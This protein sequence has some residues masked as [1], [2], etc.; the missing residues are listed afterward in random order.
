MSADRIPGD[1]E[2]LQITV[3]RFGDSWA[4]DGSLPVR[5]VPDD[6]IDAAIDYLESVRDTT[7]R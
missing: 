5:G 1:E 4:A 7:S 6:G 3:R 2:L